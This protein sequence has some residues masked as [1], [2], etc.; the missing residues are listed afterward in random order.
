MNMSIDSQLQELNLFLL[1][2]PAKGYYVLY[3]PLA[4]SMVVVTQSDIENLTSDTISELSQGV[5]PEFREGH[6]SCSNDF[7]NLSILPNNKCNFTCTYCYSAKG[8]SNEQLNLE[9]VIKIIDFFT[10]PTRNSAKRL[11]VTFFGG[12]EPLIS[13]KEIVEPS[14]I[15]LYS[16]SPRKI[17]TTIITNGSLI[18]SGFIDAC[19]KYRIDL[20]CSYEILEDVQ[21]AQRKNYKL[22]TDNIRELINAG[23]VPAINSVVTSLNV[24]RLQDMVEQLHALFPEIKHLA[25]EP[26]MEEVK[27][28]PD[29]FYSEFLYHFFKA[30]DK[31]SVYGMELTCSALR[32]VD[33]CVDRYCA[34][35]LA[36]CPDGSISICPCCSS[37]KDSHYKEY[38]YGKVDSDG[39]IID[40]KRLSELLSE[41]VY[42][43]SWCKDCFAKWNCGGGCIQKTHQRGGQQD[44]FFCDFVRR[45]TKYELLRRLDLA[46]KDSD[47][48]L[49]D[50]IGDYESIIR[51]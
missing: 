1:N 37:S 6:I 30:R 25:V 28:T 50:L 23:V 4:D 26:V 22:V 40:N 11:H 48:N 36:L 9:Q 29:S 5:L 39:V 51:Q 19:L 46:Y 35:E 20:V 3:A 27:T 32:N 44:K 42:S 47:I 13:W 49:K 33:T 10:D 18:P 41:N 14:L 45:F 16:S 8:R 38:I 17:I 34:G 21:N 31:A 43:Q 12:G 15:Y 24:N 2:V 7:L